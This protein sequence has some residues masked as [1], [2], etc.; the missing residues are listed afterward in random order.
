[1][2]VPRATNSLYPLGLCFS[3]REVRERAGD[4]RRPPGSGG[5]GLCLREGAGWGAVLSLPDPRRRLGLLPGAPAPVP[6]PPNHSLLPTAAFRAEPE[7]RCFPICVNHK[8]INKSQR[9]R[10][11]SEVFTKSR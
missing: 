3:L 9:A 6:R 10:A 1:M 8:Q 7:A 11:D 5:R 4:P 2:L